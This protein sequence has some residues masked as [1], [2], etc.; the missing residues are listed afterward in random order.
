MFHNVTLNL[1]HILKQTHKKKSNLFVVTV[2]ISLWC[3]L[4]RWSYWI[5]GG[6]YPTGF[7]IV[8]VFL[9][10]VVSVTFLF[11]VSFILGDGR[12]FSSGGRF[13]FPQPN[14]SLLAAVLFAVHPI[15]TESVSAEFFC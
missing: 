13:L 8:N 10:G 12:S 7:H 15:H 1:K 6:L 2:Q 14:T 4:C 5:A 9:H 11:F 3:G